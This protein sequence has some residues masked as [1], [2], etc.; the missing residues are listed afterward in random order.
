MPSHPGTHYPASCVKGGFCAHAGFPPPPTPAGGHQ[1]HPYG[2]G[3]SSAGEDEPHPYGGGDS[4]LFLRAF[5]YPEGTG[6]RRCPY[7]L[8]W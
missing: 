1:V 6:T 5:V 2:E 7:V 3:N 8:L 4:S